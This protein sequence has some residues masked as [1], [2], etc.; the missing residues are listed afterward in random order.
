MSEQPE[1]LRL[2]DYLTWYRS[3]HCGEASAELRRLYAQSEMRRLALLEELQKSERLHSVNAELLEALNA[4]VAAHA[5]ILDLRESDELQLA[6]L[7]IA[8]A[9]G[10]T[11]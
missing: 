4:L 11:K 1:A 7:A 3:P 2:A 10:E 9:T 8:K 5:S 6:R